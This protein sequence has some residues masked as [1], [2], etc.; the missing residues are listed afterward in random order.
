[1]R[2][3]SCRRLG[4][5]KHLDK[6][7]AVN[8]AVLSV[9]RGGLSVLTRDRGATRLT[10]RIC[11]HAN[12]LGDRRTLAIWAVALIVVLESMGIPLPLAAICAGAEQSS[13][14]AS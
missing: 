12:Q 6:R 8:P 5:S 9:E 1:M 14:N 2:S 13:R 3:I 7:A 11:A 10:G 4:K